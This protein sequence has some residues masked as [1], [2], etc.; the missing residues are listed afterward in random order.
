MRSGDLTFD[1]AV[2]A[3]ASRNSPEPVPPRRDLPGEYVDSHCHLTTLFGKAKIGKPKG[4]GHGWDAEIVQGFCHENFGPHCRA[5]V[6]VSCNV[7][8][9]MPTMRLLEAFQKPGPFHGRVWSSFGIHPSNA[10]ELVTGE[11]PMG[12]GKGK[13]NGKGK[14]RGGGRSVEDQLR[15]ALS[16]PQCVA[17]GEFGIDYS[18]PEARASIEMQEESFRMQVRLGKEF[19]KPLVL[20]LRHHK[21]DAPGDGRKM[22]DNERRTLDLMK[23]EIDAQAPFHVHCFGDTAAFLHAIKRHFPNAYFGFTG[24]ALFERAYNTYQALCETP[25]NRLLL[26]TDAPYMA[27]PP[28]RGLLISHPGQVPVIAHWV[29][30]A[31]G[32]SLAKLLDETTRNA[33]ALYGLGQAPQPR[34]AAIPPYCAVHSEHSNNEGAAGSAAAPSRAA[35]MLT[36]TDKNFLK[37]CK[38]VRDIW[39]LEAQQGLAKNQLDKI[40][41][42]LDALNEVR[43]LLKFLPADSNLRQN[44]QDVISAASGAA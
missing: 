24:C 23:A 21:A 18:R 17:V 26:E 13:D 39:K 37:F 30:E 8:D 25:L 32:V 16:H 29:A 12:K 4:G 6:H 1:A 42:K 20:H 19:G 10:Y 11:G 15:D 14:G 27:V 7:S 28:F 33:T 41:K 22:F 36:Q 43:N 44:N 38:V 34:L 3:E 9:F 40:A 5:L 31:H 35:S 2:Q